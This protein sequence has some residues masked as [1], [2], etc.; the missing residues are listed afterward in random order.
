[1]KR[2]AANVQQTRCFGRKHVKVFGKLLSSVMWLLGSLLRAGKQRSIC[3]VSETSNQSRLRGSQPWRLRHL[4]VRAIPR[5]HHADIE[6]LIDI[7][8]E[9]NES[10]ARYRDLLESQQDLIFR[11]DSEGRLTF[12]NSAFCKTFNIEA[13]AALESVFAPAVSSGDK[14][15]RL[16]PGAGPRSRRYVQEIETALGRRWFDFEEHV[17]PEV[18]G[19]LAETQVVARDITDRRRQESELAEARDL[20]EAA[21]RAKSRFLAAMSHE[22]RTPMNGILGMSGL[23]KETALNG[24]QRTYVT[25]IDQ[26]ARTLLALIDEI[27]DFS[28]IEAGK[29]VLESRPFS[30]EDCVQSVVELL[31]PRATE[32][33]IE[34]AWA[35]DPALPAVMIADEVRVRQII[36]NLVGNAIKFTHA[37]GVLVRVSAGQSGKCAS[38]STARCVISVSD[39]GIGIAPE[40]MRTLFAEF[41]Q[42][43]ATVHRRHG[44]TGLG[45][46]IS[47]R[48]ARAM[49]GDITV[50]SEH[51]KGSVFSAVLELEVGPD[52]APLRAPGR[53]YDEHHVLIIGD[54]RVEADALRLCL[55]GAH[56]PAEV[57]TVIEAGR[58]LR[59]AANAGVPFDTVIFAGLTSPDVAASL[60]DVARPAL[61]GQP[62]R[63][64][65]VVDAGGRGLI[66]AFRDVGIAN[67]VVRP[68]RPTSLLRECSNGPSRRCSRTRVKSREARNV[69]NGD[70]QRVDACTAG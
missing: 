6:N 67:Y 59:A 11:R 1:M 37:G 13:R 22:I 60:C 65:A 58:T 20:A 21:N 19:R 5:L 31:A 33:R 18:P 55:E 53:D 32:K 35:I 62:L 66:E 43:D 63:A 47:R 38:M 41:E 7:R 4:R 14:V 52:A 56:V 12:V 42:G 70:R 45:L 24:E 39:T 8:W 69:E 10:E 50:A 57:A 49:N 68:V 17:V 15:D 2:D 9:I 28:K 3:L 34:L 64:I 36:T 26:S 51:G 16:T 29:L 54:G 27:L 25:A 44:G 30:I 40:K 46:A 48:L 61:S 23:I